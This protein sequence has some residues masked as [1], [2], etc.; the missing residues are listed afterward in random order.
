LV[1]VNEYN[2]FLG[3]TKCTGFASFDVS[4]QSIRWREGLQQGLSW[5]EC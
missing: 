4:S 2:G 1:L 3:N 5:E